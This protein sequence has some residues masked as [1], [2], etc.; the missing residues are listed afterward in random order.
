ME[1]DASTAPEVPARPPVPAPTAAKEK[2]IT[3]PVMV[4]E[5][6]LTI[7]SDMMLKGHPGGHATN[8]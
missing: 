5:A 1:T 3:V 6:D 8:W 4:E 2:V 7:R